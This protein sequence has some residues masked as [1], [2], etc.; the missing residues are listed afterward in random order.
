MQFAQTCQSS[1]GDF[2]RGSF[3]INGTPRNWSD[4]ADGPALQT[5]A[6]LQLFS[7]LDAP[8][9]AV[10]NAVI[11]ANLNFL[12]GAYQG[13]TLVQGRPGTSLATGCPAVQGGIASG[14]DLCLLPLEL[15]FGDDAAVT[16]VGQ[17]R[18]LVRRTGR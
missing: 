11:A 7:Q 2:D 6:I 4:Q 8:A 3:F 14:Q 13:E 17:L 16:E 1:G 18:Q 9:Q 15:L 5:L 12:Q 10:A